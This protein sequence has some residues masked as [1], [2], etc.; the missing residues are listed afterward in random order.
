MANTDRK[1]ESVDVG[2]V[3]KLARILGAF[4]ENLN[5]LSKELGVVALKS[6]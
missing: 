5:F 1:I 2:S 3:D 6:A 4:D